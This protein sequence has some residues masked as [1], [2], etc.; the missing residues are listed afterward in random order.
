MRLLNV[1]NLYLKKVEIP[2][3]SNLQIIEIRAFSVSNIEEIYIP[4][5]VSKICEGAFYK[6]KNLK[7][8]EIPTKS[9]LQTIEK[10]T[11]SNYFNCM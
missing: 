11:F 9:N 6:C 7:K 2:P 8:V 1:L 3:N 4:P 10:C 5:N